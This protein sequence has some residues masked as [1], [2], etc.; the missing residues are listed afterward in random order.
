MRADDR[1]VV[2][3]QPAAERVGQQLLGH[4][5]HELLRVLQQRLAQR[6]PGRRPACRRPADPTA[7]TTPAASFVRHSP[8]ASK[9]SSEKPSGSI[10][11][12]QVAHAGFARCCSSALAHRH[13]LAALAVFLERRHVRRRRRR[14]R[15]EDVLQ[16]PLAAQHRRRAVGIRR[17]GQDAALAEQAAAVLVGERHAAELAAVDVRDAVVARQPLVDERVVGRQQVE[18]VAV[19]AH[20]ALEEQLGLLRNACRRL[21]SKFGNSSRVGHE[22]LQIA[23]RTATA[24]RSCR[25]APA[26]A[27]PRASAGPAARAPPDP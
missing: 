25:P 20:D 13:R 10:T 15:A 26:T 17:D 16:N 14:R 2:I 22:A 6:R 11:R 19:L 23:Q 18:D 8:V 12:W 21:S 3:L 7:S 5:P 24:R 1:H 4:R 27:G 9:F